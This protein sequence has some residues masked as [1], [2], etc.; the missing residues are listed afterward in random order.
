MKI[1]FIFIKLCLWLCILH[2]SH[3]NSLKCKNK[4]NLYVLYGKIWRNSGK[5]AS[6][7]NQLDNPICHL[8]HIK[9]NNHANYDKKLSWNEH[10][11][12]FQF[13]S[14]L[15]KFYIQ[16]EHFSCVDCFV[17]RVHRK[18]KGFLRWKWKKRFL[19]NLNIFFCLCLHFLSLK[20]CFTN[21]FCVIFICA[22]SDTNEL[23]N[24]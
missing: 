12:K 10:E 3:R 17:C 6:Q 9:V 19:K 13:D 7:V 14:I 16:I 5:S 20:Y 4:D 8:N 1:Y 15:H 18:R 23:Q 2:V 11:K 21:Q 24:P 22:K